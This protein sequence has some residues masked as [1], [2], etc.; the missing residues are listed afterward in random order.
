LLAIIKG[1]FEKFSKKSW[2]LLDNLCASSIIISMNNEDKKPVRA[3]DEV[4]QAIPLACTDET[5]A[6]EFMEKQRWGEHPACPHCGSIK[7]SKMTDKNGGR[8][9][10]FLWRCH[11]CKDQFTVRIG[12]VF[13]DSRIPLKIWCHAFW[14]ACA[15]KKGVS[16]LQIK[17]ECSVTYKTALFLMH[18]IRC[19]MTEPQQQEQLKGIVEVDETYVGGKPRRGKKHI[20]T[21]HRFRGR[22]TPKTPVLALVER[23]GDVRARVVPN[24]T[25]KTLGDIMIREIHPSTRIM[26]DDYR[27]YRTIGK[28]FA[29]H[30][31]TRHSSGEYARGDV[32]SNTAESFFAI[33]KRGL[34]G[35]FH[36]VS[37]KHLHRYISEF[38]F[39]WNTR[40]VNDGERIA[41]AIK[42]AEGK[43]LMYR[44]PTAKSA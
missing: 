38:S 22:G 24:V 4:L 33:L 28:P 13:E 40:Q 39:R 44:E 29:G 16:A 36:A 41:E 32:Y 9:K 27:A 11:D 15:S 1:I 30:E 35:T 20:D 31:F 3:K 43:R 14:R 23:N 12:T 5:A 42:S 10:R 37:K 2:I 8:N 18:R 17:R 7:V 21:D 25:A 34:Y 26:T 19:A 6:V